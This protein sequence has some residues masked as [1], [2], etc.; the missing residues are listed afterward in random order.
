MELHI[1]PI[2]LCPWKRHDDS[3]KGSPS[4][5]ATRD[6][7]FDLFWA[8]IAGRITK[9]MVSH[10]QKRWYNKGETYM[11]SIRQQKTA[12]HYLVYRSIAL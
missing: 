1:L 10:L 11:H 8:T 12:T 4:A 3:K 5:P 2:S 6:Q 7:H 9:K